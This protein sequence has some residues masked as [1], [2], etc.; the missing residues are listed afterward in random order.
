MDSFN[1]K[2]AILIYVLLISALTVVALPSSTPPPEN[3]APSLEKKTNV[4]NTVS[5][6]MQVVQQK[7]DEFKQ[8][9]NKRKDDPNTKPI[10]KDCITECNEVIDAAID[11]IKKSLESLGT[12]NLDKANFDVT[13]ISNNIAT[14]SECFVEMG[15]DEP[16]VKKMDDWVRGVTGDAI[17]SLDKASR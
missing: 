3:V 7:L 8:M 12:Q 14:C 15:E 11:D 17:V 13:A 5:K 16:M 9:L 4:A 2:M 6:Q 1:H 10:A